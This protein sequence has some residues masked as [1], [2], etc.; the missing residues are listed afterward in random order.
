MVANPQQPER[1]FFIRNGD[2]VDGPHPTSRILAW[3]REGKLPD[4][5]LLSADG[6]RWRPVRWPGGTGGAGRRAS[7]ARGRTPRG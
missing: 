6:Q 4:D 5:I 2:H 3:R 7:A 1:R